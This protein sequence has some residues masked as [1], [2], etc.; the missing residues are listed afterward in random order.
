MQKVQ[1]NFVMITNHLWTPTTFISTTTKKVMMN[2]IN[3]S[4][5]LNACYIYDKDRNNNFHRQ[6]EPS[7]IFNTSIEPPT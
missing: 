4:Q 1:W 6:R 5:I 2:N 3:N 7:P